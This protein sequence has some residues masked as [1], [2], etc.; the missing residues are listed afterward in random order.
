MIVIEMNEKSMSDL[1]CCVDNHN[2]LQS[3]DHIVRNDRYIDKVNKSHL[4]GRSHC[5]NSGSRKHM[6]IPTKHLLTNKRNLN[7]APPLY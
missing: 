4:T 5:C 2:I 7:A 3:L 6:L 1:A